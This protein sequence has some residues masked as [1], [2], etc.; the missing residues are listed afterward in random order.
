MTKIPTIYLLALICA[1]ELLSTKQ[2]GYGFNLFLLYGIYRVCRGI[3][4]S[5]H[6][7]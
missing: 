6:A 4:R 2:M 3:H 1:I 7:D 5:M